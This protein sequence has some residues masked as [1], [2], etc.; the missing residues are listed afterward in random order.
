MCRV[1]S[2]L[3]I[4]TIERCYFCHLSAGLSRLYMYVPYRFVW[5]YGW[6]SIAICRLANTFLLLILA[7]FLSVCQL[8]SLSVCPLPVAICDGRNV[9]K[10]NRSFMLISVTAYT[11]IHIHI[12]FICYLFLFE[13]GHFSFTLSLSLFLCRPYLFVGRL[14]TQ[15]ITWQLRICLWDTEICS[16]EEKKARTTF[17]HVTRK[18]NNTLEN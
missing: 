8:V 10:R 6:Q 11:L 4:S 2:S 18:K 15:G 5:V 12:S 13:S 16:Q 1:S 7:P 9:R 17:L 3:L 14:S